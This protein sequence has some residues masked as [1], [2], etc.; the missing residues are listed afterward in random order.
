MSNQAEV[1]RLMSKLRINVGLK[2]R[3]IRNVQGYRGQM[4]A[5]RKNVSALIT[6]ERIELPENRGI[7]T[8]QYTEKLISDAILNGD[9]HTETMERTKFWLE[10]DDTAIYKLFDVLVPRFQDFTTAYTRMLYAP[11]TIVP[12]GEYEVPSWLQKSSKNVVLVELKGHPFPPLYYSNTRPNPKHIHN[13]LLNAA[14]HDAKM[15]GE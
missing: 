6:H 8:R 14:K 1:L 10:N 4:D 9:K 12:F 5:L 3:K 15:R 13:V 11:R 2:Q 7:I